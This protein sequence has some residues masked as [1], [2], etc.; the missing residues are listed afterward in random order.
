MPTRLT[1]RWR[2]MVAM[3]L[4]TA[5]LAACAAP[6]VVTHNSTVGSSSDGTEVAPDIGCGNCSVYTPQQIRAAYG[7]TSLYDSGKRGQGQTVVLIESY[8][9]P[10][11]KHD[12]DVFDQQFGL[13][14]PK[15]TILSPIGTIP[16]DS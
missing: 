5:T 6:S 3:A 14:T 12:L 7:V 13:P 11:I 16:F 8:G 1:G 10:T 15:L 2:L 4:M 9:S